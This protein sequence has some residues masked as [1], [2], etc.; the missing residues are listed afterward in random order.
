MT[1][2]GRLEHVEVGMGV[3]ILVTSNGNRFQLDGHVPQELCDTQVVAVGTEQATHGFAMLP[4]DGT[5]VL[6]EPL[7][8]A[9]I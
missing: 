2:E 7:R 8:A 1:I 9:P 3:W 4:V 5:F 6:T